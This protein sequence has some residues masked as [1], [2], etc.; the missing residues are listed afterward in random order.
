M[1]HTGEALLTA[2]NAEVAEKLRN[3]GVPGGQPYRIGLTGNIATGKSTV[4]QMLRDLGAD[5]L[6]ADRLTHAALAPAGAAYDRVVA[7]FGEHILS[8]DRTI[9]RTV[10]G[11]LVFNDPEA[12]AQLEMIVHPP[13]VAEVERHIAQSR[14]A[15]VVVEAIK[16][17]E[18]GLAAGYDAIWVT[19]CPEALQL[20]RL[21]A[22]RNLTREDA[23]R[24]IHAQSPQSAK[25]ARA[26]IVL[27][28]DAT[29]EQTR[30][31]VL[32][33]W[34]GVMKRET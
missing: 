12:L 8:V 13:V 18:S 17:L 4:A 11:A 27:N 30:T 3:P 1:K 15:V 6:D 7:A 28:T 19:T 22:T 9:N 24:R 16:L 32:A 14:S 23:L 26:D 34:N 33:A 10:L 20:E 29:L 5:V 25:I 21:L 2:E 31:Q